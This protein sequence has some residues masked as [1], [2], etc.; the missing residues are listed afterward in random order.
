MEFHRD[1]HKSRGDN[2]DFVEEDN[3]AQQGWFVH[4]RQART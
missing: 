1:C 3:V 4:A 2:E